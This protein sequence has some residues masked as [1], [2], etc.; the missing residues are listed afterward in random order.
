MHVFRLARKQSAKKK[1]T[2]TKHLCGDLK[3]CGLQ[4]GKFIDCMNVERIQL[5]FV[6]DF[7]N[8][9]Q[10]I[11]AILFFSSIFKWS[12][13]YLTLVAPLQFPSTWSMIIDHCQSIECQTA[14]LRWKVHH[15]WIAQKIDAKS[16]TFWQWEQWAHFS[17]SHHITSHQRAPLTVLFLPALLFFS[18]AKRATTVSSKYY[19][20]QIFVCYWFMHYN[21]RTLKVSFFHWIL[22]VVCVFF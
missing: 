15:T 5:E 22:V 4:N 6:L 16:N 20:K 7:L 2:I 1:Q 14:P 13:D 12:L 17:R 8:G 10:L 19:Y 21:R 3:E 11:I 9:V 18:V